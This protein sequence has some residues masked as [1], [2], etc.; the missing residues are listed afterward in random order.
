M[1]KI[2]E[3]AARV[4]QEAARDVTPG[5]RS[6]RLGSC[7]RRARHLKGSG[8]RFFLTERRMCVFGFSSYFFLFCCCCLEMG[9]LLVIEQVLC[10][11]NLLM[12]SLK[13]II[14]K[15]STQISQ[16][17]HVMSARNKQIEAD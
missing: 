7:T 14:K 13:I 10:Y 4:E 15:K 8:F 1:H 12:I 5:D 2:T 3:G 11:I 16:V 9:R 6:S 17:T